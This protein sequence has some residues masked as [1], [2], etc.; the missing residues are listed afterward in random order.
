MTKYEFIAVFNWVK[1]MLSLG[2]TD[3]RPYR[4]HARNR[5]CC[6]TALAR[7]DV[8]DKPAPTNTSL[9]YQPEVKFIATPFMQ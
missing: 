1:H 3:V 7:T 2:R 6:Q 8:L 9:S 5:E 4:C